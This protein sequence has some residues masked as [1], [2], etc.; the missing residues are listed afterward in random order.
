M[1]KTLWREGFPSVSRSRSKDGPVDDVVKFHSEHYRPDNALLYVVG[2]VK[3][4]DVEL[5]IR[6]AFDGV[7]KATRVPRAA[8][9]EGAVAAFSAYCPRVVRWSL[10]HDALRGAY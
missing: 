2:D 4:D 5:A 7:P 8:L 10:R 6:T 3:A 1:P 9:P